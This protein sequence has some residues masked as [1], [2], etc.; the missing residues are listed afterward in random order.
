MN[1]LSANQINFSSI[2]DEDSKCKT[3]N[4]FKTEAEARAVKEKLGAARVLLVTASPGNYCVDVLV[5]NTMA[6]QFKSREKFH[7]D[8]VKK[9]NWIIRKVGS[10]PVEYDLIFSTC[11]F[12]QLATEESGR[13]VIT[14]RGTAIINSLRSAGVI[15]FVNEDIIAAY[16][17]SNLEKFRDT[18]RKELQFYAPQ[19][20]LDYSEEE[21]RRKDHLKLVERCKEFE[22]KKKG[23]ENRHAKNSTSHKRSAASHPDEPIKKF[24]YIEQR[25]MESGYKFATLT[26]IIPEAD[27]NETEE[28]KG[29]IR[30]MRTKT[31]KLVLRSSV[32]QRSCNICRTPMKLF[33]VTKLD[34]ALLGY[35]F[36]TCTRLIKSKP[37]ITCNFSEYFEAEVTSSGVDLDF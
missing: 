32:P 27:K 16:V 30:D 35:F 15:S 25:N 9:K 31:A 26:K 12:Y 24:R 13:Q 6:V 23:K 1:I 29:L 20:K 22:L 18:L 19:L 8:D 34:S 36:A 17:N 10:R 21:E 4:S 28:E 33:K 2:S 3:T 5:D 14:G 37:L 11:S 7:I